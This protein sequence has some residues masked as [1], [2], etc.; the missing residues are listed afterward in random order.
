MTQEIGKGILN[1]FS[2]TARETRELGNNSYIQKA[3][4][5]GTHDYALLY[6]ENGRYSS[7]IMIEDSPDE[8]HIDELMAKAEEQ[9]IGGL[10]E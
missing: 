10:L 3:E 1:Y 5:T 4:N 8:E 6:R 2:I 7:P 9:G